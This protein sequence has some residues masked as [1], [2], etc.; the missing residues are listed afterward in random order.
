MLRL[1]INSSSETVKDV[2]ECLPLTLANNEGETNI[3][4][5]MLRLTH[6][7]NAKNILLLRVRRIWAKVDR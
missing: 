2:L 1:A 4:I 5:H 7:Y 3:I 6:T